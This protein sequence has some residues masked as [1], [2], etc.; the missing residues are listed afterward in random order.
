MLHTGNMFVYWDFSNNYK[1]NPLSTASMALGTNYKS[2]SSML[3]DNF[4]LVNSRR[5]IFPIKAANNPRSQKVPEA[6]W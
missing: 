5:N 3:L 2:S 6:L 1:K 4:W